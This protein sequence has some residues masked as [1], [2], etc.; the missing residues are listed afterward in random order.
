MTVGFCP[1]IP[2]LMTA[3][4]WTT[5]LMYYLYSTL[6]VQTYGADTYT[7]R[8]KVHPHLKGI[9]THFPVSILVLSCGLP[10][11]VYRHVRPRRRL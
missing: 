2:L 6:H 11:E 8:D 4:T 3:E 9:N 10:L 5:W 1:A 7:P